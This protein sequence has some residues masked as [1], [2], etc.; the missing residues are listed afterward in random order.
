VQYNIIIKKRKIYNKKIEH[1]IKN[2]IKI[3]TKKKTISWFR[4]MMPVE[5][6]FGFSAF[7]FSYSVSSSFN[8]TQF[9]NGFFV[10]NV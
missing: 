7:Y 1:D 3:S 6:F 9:F 2:K 5:A 8:F 10:A 4:L